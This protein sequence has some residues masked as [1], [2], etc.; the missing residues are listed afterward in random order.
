MRCFNGSFFTLC[1][2]LGF[3][4]V[5]CSQIV[6]QNVPA[7]QYRSP[8]DSVLIAKTIRYQDLPTAGMIQQDSVRYVHYQDLPNIPPGKRDSVRSL[9]YQDLTNVKERFLRYQDLPDA[10]T[11]KKKR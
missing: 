2:I 11:D 9:R 5:T 3:A 1:L 8:K 10:Q 7:R 6:N 4:N